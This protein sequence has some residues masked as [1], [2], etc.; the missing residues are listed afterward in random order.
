MRK[1][2]SKKTSRGVKPHDYLPVEEKE[3]YRWLQSLE[4][5]EEVTGSADIV[6]V[7]DREADL[8]DFFKYSHQIGATVLV[9]A[10]ADRTINRIS[11]YAERGVV[12]LWWCPERSVT[13]G[14]NGI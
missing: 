3:S 14:W 4:N 13:A 9:R 1:F 12:K 6:T 7:C 8:Y 5:T 10:N 2:R 11:R